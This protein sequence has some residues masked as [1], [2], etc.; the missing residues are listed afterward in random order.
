VLL[1]LSLSFRS[2]K[3]ALHAYQQE[4]GIASPLSLT[5]DVA[6]W[7]GWSVWR[8][9]FAEEAASNH[10]GEGGNVG[11]GSQSHARED[12]HVH[13]SRHPGNRGCYC[14]EEEEEGE[15]G[16]EE[17]EDRC[18]YKH[19]RAEE[20]VVE[21]KKR[22]DI[23]AVQKADVAYV[24]SVHKENATLHSTVKKD[25]AVAMS[26]KKKPVAGMAHGSTHTV[27]IKDVKLEVEEEV[28]EERVELH[29]H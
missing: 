5:Y 12:K 7:D 20:Q 22:H 11:V 17:E 2:S 28:V 18:H 26:Q 3:E 29:V 8:G 27:Q 23:E 25:T 13:G 24:E 21:K 14:V 10:E 15:E 4:A 1:P 19:A 16:E 9:R 6:G